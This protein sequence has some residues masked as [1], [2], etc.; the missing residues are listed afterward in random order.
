MLKNIISLSIVI[1]SRFFGLFIVLP[2]L[3]IYAFNLEGANKILV[4]LLMGIYAL[5]Q[6]ILQIPFGALSD[7]IGRKK[8]IAIGLIIFIIGSIICAST[9]NIYIMIFGR[10]LQGSGAIGSVATAMIADFTK[11]E[12]RSKAMAIMGMSIGLSFAL[13]LIISPIISAKFGFNSLFLIS[14]FVSLIGLILLFVA[15]SKE[16]IIKMVDEKI[17]LKIVLKNKDIVIITFVNFFQKMLMNSIFL[18]IPYELGKNFLYPKEE[19]YKIYLLC[20]IFGL[21]SMALSGIFADKKKISKN[22]IL[23]AILC[24]IAGFFF[25]AISSNFKILSLFVFGVVTF[26]IGFNSLEPIL[27]SLISKY[28]KSNQK[29]ATIGAF[30]LFG[31]LGNFLGGFLPLIMYLNN[32][33][34]YFCAIILICGIFLFFVVLNSLRNPY[35]FKNLY[36]NKKASINLEKIASLKG[37]EDVY[38]T[39]D[40]IVIKYNSILTNED[41]L[42]LK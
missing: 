6:M 1:G 24:F 11:E 18:L 2:V 34:N 16:P 13:S 22:I 23:G 3:G 40:N 5:M 9:N 12:N 32:G 28:A 21:I 41:K 10:F 8:T 19:F 31:Y 39:K 38:E 35:I 7:K 15:V 29:G 36:L 42:N 33:V 14:A 20:V 17:P 26:F 27:Q 37:V 4:S 25:I 30:N